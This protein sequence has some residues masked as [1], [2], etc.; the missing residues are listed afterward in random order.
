MGG[1]AGR[2]ATYSAAIAYLNGDMNAEAIELLDSI[3][4]SDPEGVWSIESAYYLGEA[5]YDEESYAKARDA[6]QNAAHRSDGKLLFNALYGIGWTWFR[7]FEWNSAASSF[8]EAARAA[9][10]AEQRAKA[11]FRVGISLAS[12]ENW[13]EALTAYEN[14]LLVE[15]EQWREETLYQKAWALLNL[16]R[17]EEANRTARV[18]SEKFPDS[19]LAADLPFRMG[20]NAMR[21][22]RFTEAIRW[23][24][25][26]QVQ[27]PGKETAIQAELR[28]ALAA[29]EVGDI[30][31]ASKRYGTWVINHPEN[32]GASAAIR[33]WAQMLKRDGNL[34]LALDA[35]SKIMDSLGNNLSLSAPIILVWARLALPDSTMLV[36]AIAEDE[37]LL[38]VDRSEALLLLAHSYLRKENFDRSRELYEVLVRDVPGRIGAEAQEGLAQAYFA[39]GRLDEAA[40]AYMAI[41]YLFPDQEDL[42]DNAL[43]EAERLFREVGRIEEADKI[44]ES[45]TQ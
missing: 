7:Q 45:I 19:S 23:Y 4:Q 25:R 12:G 26:T 13:E 32:P 34:S 37:S 15:D 40:E 41:P 39:E 21:D 9:I 42:S 31:D 38:P 17:I 35:K 14:A 6:Y 8:E 16:N 10:T 29:K 5:Y 11:N 36:Q 22:G 28:A 20:E 27:Y 3:V 24:D 43:R 2:R 1:E 33:S 44:R 18:M 30:E